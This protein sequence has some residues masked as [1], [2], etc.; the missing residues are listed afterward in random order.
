MQI[1]IL[2]PLNFLPRFSLFHVK[3][4]WPFCGLSHLRLRNGV[5]VWTFLF[6]LFSYKHV[7]QWNFYVSVCSFNWSGG[8]VAFWKSFQI[9]FKCSSLNFIPTFQFCVTAIN[10]CLSVSSASV[11]FYGNFVKFLIC[12][13]LILCGIQQVDLKNFTLFEI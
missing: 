5:F 9:Q 8:R 4:I 10:W 3:H 7:S 11:T 2:I 6:Y 13:K 12:L 1:D